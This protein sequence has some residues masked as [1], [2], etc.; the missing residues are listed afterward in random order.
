MRRG[1]LHKG[2]LFIFGSNPNAIDAENAV[3]GCILPRP[4]PAIQ[5]STNSTTS[6]IKDVDELLPGVKRKSVSASVELDS[7]DDNGFVDIDELLSDMQQKSI[8]QSLNRIKTQSIIFYHG[9]SRLNYSIVTKNTI[10]YSVALSSEF[11]GHANMRKAE[12]AGPK[13][14]NP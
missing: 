13:K 4:N 14:P 5:D 8:F 12:F 2:L 10:E 9:E 11:A 1:D 7:D 3:Q 6:N